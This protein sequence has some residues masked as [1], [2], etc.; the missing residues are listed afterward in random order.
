MSATRSESCGI[1]G[2]GSPRGV[3]YRRY[4]DGTG[5][6]RAETAPSQIF[7]CRGSAAAGGRIAADV[8]A[9]AASREPG[10]VGSLAGRQNA[11]ARLVMEAEA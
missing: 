6:F 11:R 8:V 1:S 10:L 3:P 9:T 7:H 2:A 5:K 4:C